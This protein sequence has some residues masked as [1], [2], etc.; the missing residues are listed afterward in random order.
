ATSAGSPGIDGTTVGAGSTTGKLSASRDF[1]GLGSGGFTAGGGVDTA[2]GASVSSVAGAGFDCE[3]AFCPSRRLI[4]IDL[5]N[6]F[7]ANT[8]IPLIAGSYVQSPS[9]INESV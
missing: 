6:A 4:S 7:V 1:F 9:T 2:A 8:A 5:L 3:A